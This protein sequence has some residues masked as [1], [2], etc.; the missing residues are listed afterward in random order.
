MHTGPNYGLLDLLNFWGN[1]RMK[2]LEEENQCLDRVVEA[3]P[4]QG[5]SHLACNLG[6]E[7]LRIVKG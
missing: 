7:F 4:P 3:S 2:M 6:S 1:F 5:S